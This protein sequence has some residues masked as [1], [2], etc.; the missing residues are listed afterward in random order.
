MHVADYTWHMLSN[1]FLCHRG[2]QT[3]K[4]H[5]KVR[6]AQIRENGK[7]YQVREGERGERREE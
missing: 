2:F 7:K 3:V 5:S 1:V 4:T 6:R